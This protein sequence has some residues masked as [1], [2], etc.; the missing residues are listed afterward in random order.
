MKMIEKNEIED[1][2]N[3]LINSI[4][5]GYKWTENNMKLLEKLTEYKKINSDLLK[6]KIL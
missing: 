4:D 2:I 3:N 5:S 1:A 6:V